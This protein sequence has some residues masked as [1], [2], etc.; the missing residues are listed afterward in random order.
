[1]K[2][3][4]EIIDSLENVFK[5]RL[6][7][8]IYGTFLISWLIFHWEFVFT[9]LFVSEDK[10]W[11]SMGLLK[12]EYLV[13]NFFNFFDWYLYLSWILPFILTWLIIWKFPKWISLPAFKKDEEYRLE[14]TK[15]RITEQKKVETEEIKFEQEKKKKLN[16]VRET[17]KKEKE[18]EK[19]DPTINWEKEYEIFKNTQYYSNFGIII[20]SIY[21]HNGNTDWYQNNSVVKTHIPK[22][23]LAYCHTN[24]LIE[25]G[26]NNESISVS[27]KGK[28]FIRQ[29]T[30]DNKIY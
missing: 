23:I 16:V 20:E 26:K 10:I 4:N 18:I 28:F 21:Q 27:E 5:K 22:G 3:D 17:V 8:P 9:V 6:T 1:M 13:K 19:L 24:G 29:F 12:N 2:I 11:Q 14:K 15:I 30:S 7:S 25:F